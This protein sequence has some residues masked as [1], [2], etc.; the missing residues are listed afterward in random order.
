[1]F[2]R[3]HTHAYLCCAYSIHVHACLTFSWD[4]LNFLVINDNPLIGWNFRVHDCTCTWTYV[5]VRERVL[6]M[7]TTC[8]QTIRFILILTDGS[9]SNVVIERVNLPWN[10]VDVE[11]CLIIMWPGQAVRNANVRQM[12]LAFTRA[13]NSVQG[14][15]ARCVWAVCFLE[16]HRSCPQAPRCIA[17]RVV[18]SRL[19]A[20][21]YSTQCLKTYIV[22]HH[23]H[24]YFVYFYAY[25]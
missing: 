6:F 22:D 4:W 7:M 1:M 11:H 16:A 13:A 14:T 20:L 24:V 17:L 2:F 15:V 18:E 23:I 19:Q 3:K 21:L 10:G 12:C 8:T 5:N 25:M 9:I